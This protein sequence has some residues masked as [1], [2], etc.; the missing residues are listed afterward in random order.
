MS[1]PPNPSSPPTLAPDWDS[2]VDGEPQQ[3]EPSDLVS[4]SPIVPKPQDD[5]QPPPPYP[6]PPVVLVGPAVFASTAALMWLVNYYFPIGPLLRI[7]F[8][9]PIALV[10]LRRGQRAAW[11]TALVSTLLVTVLMGPT[12][13][14]LFLMPFAFLGVLL[15]SC[16]RRGSGWMLSIG[17]GTLL[18]SIGLFFRIWV[19][20][21]LLG[22]DL[23]LY[24]TLQMTEFLDWAFLKLG[25]LVQPQLVLIQLLAFGAI[26]LNS[27]IY[28]LTVH[29]LAFLLLERVGNPIPPPP[30]WIQVLVEI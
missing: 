27:L 12:R 22:D 24:L 8:P 16:W 18:A 6:P 5:R 26:V 28:L 19:T 21:L 30:P 13:S 7:C 20:S 3:V 2:W 14:L 23:W 11:M 29:L 25:L 9:I 1:Q 15:G 4:P 10:Y 17:L